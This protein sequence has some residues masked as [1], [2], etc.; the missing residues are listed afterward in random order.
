MFELSLMCPEDRIEAV[1]DALDALD[2]LSVSV[3]DA[4]AQTDA[5]QALFGEPGMP[6]PKEGWQRSRVVAL[7]ETEAAASEAQ[8]LLAVQDFFTG[9]KVLGLAQVPEQD[10]VRLTQSQFAPVDITPDFWIVPTWHEL[11]AQALRSIRLDPGLAF[12]TGTHPTTR[13]CLRWIARHGATSAA[14][15]N[16]L[17]RVLDYGCGSG[18]LA[19]GA[20]KF[21]ATDIDAVDID[22][23]AVES[24]MQ[25]ALANGV[26]VQAGLP[27]KAQ[28]LYQTVLANILATPLRV[29]APLLCAHVAPGGHLVLAGILER[30]AQELQEAY[31]PWIRLE[32]ADAEDGWILMTASR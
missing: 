17:G 28:G 8:Q 19:I 21:G 13:M 23:A 14:A 32:V 11:P 29:L 9:C 10:W 5:E 16:P 26:Q 6:P 31:A 4:D 3:E 20:A 15:G 12:G 24:T 25:N 1:S 27:D 2:A 18:I 30:Q 7:F 22:P